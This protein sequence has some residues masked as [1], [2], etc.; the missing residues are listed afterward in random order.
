MVN[1]KICTAIFKIQI[2]QKKC[3]LCLLEKLEIINFEDQDPLL[4]KP[5]DLIS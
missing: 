1:S 3:L 5:P 2:Y 4:K